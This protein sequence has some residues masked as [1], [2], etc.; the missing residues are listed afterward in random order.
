MRAL[1]FKSEMDTE[2]WKLHMLVNQRHNETQFTCL[3]VSL[4][5][6]L[7]DIQNLNKHLEAWSFLSF[8]TT[9]CVEC[10]SYVDCFNLWVHS[11]LVLHPTSA[12]MLNY[13]VVYSVSVI[14]FSPTK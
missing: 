10:W 4:N 13:T 5:K 1:G 7:H 12:L 3:F 6:V 14:G 11:G 2:K 9:V 8:N